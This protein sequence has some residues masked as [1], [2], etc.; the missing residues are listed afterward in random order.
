MLSYFDNY[1]YYVNSIEGPPPPLGIP[2]GEGALREVCVYQERVLSIQGLKG[3]FSEIS[4]KAA[5]EQNM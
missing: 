2:G 3:L 4:R 5:K 1:M